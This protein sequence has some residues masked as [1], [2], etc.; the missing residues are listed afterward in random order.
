MAATVFGAALTI[1]GLGGVYCQGHFWA[2][3]VV[4]AMNPGET[5]LALGLPTLVTVG[6]CF[7]VSYEI[8]ASSFT[9]AWGRDRR[10][11]M[12]SAFVLFVLVSGMLLSHLAGSVAARALQTT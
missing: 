4:A 11:W 2:S 1:A 12:F 3:G 5:A 6:G 10:F 9:E 7:V 8:L